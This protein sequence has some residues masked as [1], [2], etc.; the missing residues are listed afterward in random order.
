MLAPEAVLGGGGGR[1]AFSRRSPGTRTYVFREKGAE[2][3]LW[4]TDRHRIGG[5][6][7]DIGLRLQP[8]WKHLIA[9]KDT[10]HCV[11]T[12]LSTPRRCLLHSILLFLLPV[13]KARTRSG[14]ESSAGVLATQDFW[15]L[16]VLGDV[17]GI[18]KSWHDLRRTGHHAQ[19]QNVAS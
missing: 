2:R 12:Q 1:G 16:Q 18:W 19:L 13:R 5:S 9:P 8:R 10:R 6:T 7:R 11:I 4:G 17:T 3:L 15:G 14:S